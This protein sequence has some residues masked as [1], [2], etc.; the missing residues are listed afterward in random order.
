MM[1]K[2]FELIKPDTIKR[3]SDQYFEALGDICIALLKETAGTKQNKPKGVC[4]KTNP[5]FLSLS[6]SL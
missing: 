4:A 5:L 1:L 2:Y 6:L 3:V